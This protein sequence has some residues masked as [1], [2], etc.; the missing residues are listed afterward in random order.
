MSLQHQPDFQLPFVNTSLVDVTQKLPFKPPCKILFKNEYEQPS[1]SFKLRGIG[2]LICKSI[3]KTKARNPDK[4]IHVFASSGGNAGLAAAY[5]ARFYNVPCMVAVPN[6]TKQVIL[7][8]L[9]EYNS[10]IIMFGDSINEADKYLKTRMALYGEDIEK[11]YCH[12]FENELVW[13]GHSTMIDEISNSPKVANDNIKGVVCSIG[14]GGLYNGIHQGLQNN[15]MN[16]DI[17]LMETN[18]APTFVETIKRKEIFTLDSVKSMATSLACSYLSKKS[19]EIYMN[20]AS[21]NHTSIE[22]IDDMDA[23]RACVQYSDIFGVTI[24]PACGAAVCVAL[25]RLD[26]LLRSF[27][28]L[29]PN[30]AIVVVVCGGSC[31]DA[32]GLEEFRQLLGQAKL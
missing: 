27:K 22:S 25:N 20:Q 14:G 31:T 16:S 1:G 3:T 19:L 12:P 2:N 7:D 11:I 5:L 18:Q 6:S 4:K 30:D 24:E 28:N 21:T 10:E 23:V 17:L 32:E 8:K 15:K 29:G 9:K 13:E 26:I